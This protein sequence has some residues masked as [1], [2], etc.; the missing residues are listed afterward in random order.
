MALLPDPTTAALRKTNRVPL[1]KDFAGIYMSLPQC[2]EGCPQHATRVRHKQ[3]HRSRTVSKTSLSGEAGQA[4][5]GPGGPGLSR[6]SR[7]LPEGGMARLLRSNI[8]DFVQEVSVGQMAQGT[9]FRC[10]PWPTPRPLK[11]LGGGKGEVKGGPIFRRPFF[12]FA[13]FFFWR[14]SVLAQERKKER[15][16]RGD[17]YGERAGPQAPKG[18]LG[19]NTLKP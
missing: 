13:P 7:A 1:R 14:P 9:P 5:G 18:V 2:I 3:R 16:K 4:H 11:V 15:K 17:A 8:Q 10:L 19:C 12:F 6:G